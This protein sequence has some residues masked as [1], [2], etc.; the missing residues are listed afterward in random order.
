MGFDR[1]GHRGSS[2]RSVVKRHRMRRSKAILLKLL[3]MLACIPSVAAQPRNQLPLV[4]VL[5]TGGTIS[6]K[7][8]TSTSLAE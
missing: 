3:V 6:G 5:S 8:A 4:W 7:G 2:D 1:D